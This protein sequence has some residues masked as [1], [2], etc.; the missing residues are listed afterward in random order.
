MHRTVL[1]L[2]VVASLAAPLA[3]QD[4]AEPRR[5]TVP[6]SDPSR[7]GSVEVTMV[8]GSITVKG[9][10]RK[11]VLV[12]ARVTGPGRPPRR[13]TAANEPPPP[14]LRRLTQNAPFAHWVVRFDPQQAGLASKLEMNSIYE[15]VGEKIRE[16]FNVHGVVIYS[17]D[18]E[19]NLVS[20]EYAYEK[21]QRL[22]VP[23]QTAT[24]LQARVIQMGKTF[25]VNHHVKELFEEYQ[26][27]VRGSR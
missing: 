1:L 21:T 13:S 4:A 12:E 7:P 10:N 9:T 24:A 17:Y 3:A 6:F 14:G 19:K 18:H 11:D 27:R 2:L 26:F 8:M 16:I 5:V 23:P 20:T 22:S 15:L 25:V